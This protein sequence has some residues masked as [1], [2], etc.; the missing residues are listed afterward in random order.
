MPAPSLDSVISED[1]LAP[2]MGEIEDLETKGCY[3]EANQYLRVIIKELKLLRMARVCLCTRLEECEDPWRRFRLIEKQ[4]SNE[5]S[6]MK[7]SSPLMYLESLRLIMEALSLAS[8][9]CLSFNELQ[10][11]NTLLCQTHLLRLE[12]EADQ[13]EQRW[14]SLHQTIIQ[15]VSLH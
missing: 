12:D 11:L 8:S 4:I 2:L 9:S 10:A 7:E 15:K 5:L 13:F 1:L 6:A 3:K 14:S